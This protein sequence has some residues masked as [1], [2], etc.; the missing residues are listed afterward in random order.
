LG[1]L[2][3]PIECGPRRA[4]HWH[5]RRRSTRPHHASLPPRP[6]VRRSFQRVI[7][8]PRRFTGCSSLPQR[9]GWPLQRNGR[10]RGLYRCPRLGCSA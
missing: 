1:L 7:R 8:D 5:G 2:W 6:A 9:L 3:Q 4:R 10:A